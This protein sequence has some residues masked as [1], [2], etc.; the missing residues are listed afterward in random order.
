MADDT[1][2]CPQRGPGLTHTTDGS[3]RCADCGTPTLNRRERP[4]PRR[5]SPAVPPQAFRDEYVTARAAGLSPPDAEAIIAL[6]HLLGPVDDPY[7]PGSVEKRQRER[8]NGGASPWKLRDL[9]RLEFTRW[10][11]ARSASRDDVEG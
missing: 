4:A 9:A 5:E 6:R 2:Q 3:P 8:H 11:V 7:Q 10:R 1:E